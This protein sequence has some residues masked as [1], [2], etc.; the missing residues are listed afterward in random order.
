MTNILL[1]IQI[2]FASSLVEAKAAGE[3]S[4][5]RKKSVRKSNGRRRTAGKPF[6]SLLSPVGV[7][8]H[9]KQFFKFVYDVFLC[10]FS[11]HSRLGSH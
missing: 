8:S 4:L 10:K 7:E 2:L 11:G 6:P 3:R 1:T 9:Q 5:T